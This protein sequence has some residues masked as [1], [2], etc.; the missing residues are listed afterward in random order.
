MSESNDLHL[1]ILGTTPLDNTARPKRYVSRYALMTFSQ[2]R[3]NDSQ[4]K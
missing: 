3:L 4:M 2:F 1:L